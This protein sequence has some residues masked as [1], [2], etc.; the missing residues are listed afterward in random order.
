MN[1]SYNT[2]NMTDTTQQVEEEQER[3]FNRSRLLSHID[4]YNLSGEIE[5]VR[6]N[7]DHGGLQ[8]GF[9]S[10]DN[11]IIG[12]LQADGFAL[13]EDVEIGVMQTSRLKKLIKILDDTFD[14]SF[15]YAGDQARVMTLEDRQKTVEF[16]LAEL[17][18]IPE[19]PGLKKLPNFQ[20]EAEIT[21]QFTSDF[22]SAESALDEDEFAVRTT[23]DGVE[24]VV[25]YT[26]D[27]RRAHNNKVTLPVS[28]DEY[29]QFE[30]NNVPFKA[31][32]FAEILKA[33][34]D[35]D[36]GTWD[37]SDEGLSRIEFEGES[38]TA[39]YYFV[40]QQQV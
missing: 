32:I 20:V 37:V 5:P 26:A 18:V 35:A 33:N 30:E 10:P 13:E 25:G 14:V 2:S 6:W 12:E 15:S 8:I 4:R 24:A 27:S 19:T 1:N 29:V 9:V 39:S 3:D 17:S 16:R 38:W 40:S 34:S 36:V 28:V 23:P 11:T 22:R 31:D 21:E 7:I